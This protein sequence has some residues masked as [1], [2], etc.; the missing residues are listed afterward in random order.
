MMPILSKKVMDHMFFFAKVEYY[1]IF[2][3]S[4]FKKL[5]CAIKK[6]PLLPNNNKT[7]I[8]TPS[9]NT[10]SLCSTNQ[11]SQT[12][13][14]SR[15]YTFAVCTTPTICSYKFVLAKV[16]SI[17]KLILNCITINYAP[18]YELLDRASQ[19]IMSNPIFDWN[20]ISLTGALVPT[21]Q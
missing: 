21:N 2:Y 14:F 6:L 10:K 13:M 16:I 1:S 20:Y 7:K 18:I 15:V 3:K 17:T 4:K 19:P 12:T 9:G 11:F 8:L 5:S